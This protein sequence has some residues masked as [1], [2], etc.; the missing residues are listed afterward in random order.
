LRVYGHQSSIATSVQDCDDTELVVPF[1]PLR[2]TQIKNALNDI[3]P[4]GTTPIARSLEKA[5]DDFPDNKGRNIIILITDGVEACDEDPCAVSLALQRKGV[6]L[7]PFVIGIGTNKD[8]AY[9]FECIGNYYDA[10]NEETFENILKVVIS[11]AL[12]NTTVEVDLLDSSN[13]PTETNVPMTFYD[14]Q[15][16]LLL[17]NFV[18]TLNGKGRPDT[19]PIDPVYVYDI[20]VHT[21]PEQRIEAKTIPAGD[22]T[23]IEIPAPQGEL[24]LKIDG[25]NAYKDLKCLIR[26]DGELIHVQDFNTAE[27][28]IVGDYDIEMLTLPRIALNKVDIRQSD[29][30]LLA[31][32]TPGVLNA[33]FPAGGY[34]AVMLV[35]GDQLEWVCATD[36]R[37]TQQQIVLQPGNYKLVYR[38]QGSKESIYTITRDFTITSGGSTVVRM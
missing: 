26:K 24:E 25:R 18:H 17:Y 22:H 4:M 10:A 23:T 29:R 36:S 8:M 15:S 30:T 21:I 1:G 27:R 38:S 32:P 28:Y 12:N 37:S 13:Q 19:I 31:I 16:G 5:A 20:V 35:K 3:T 14:S 34:G 33:A 11:Q 2:Y 6:I 7:K 9:Q